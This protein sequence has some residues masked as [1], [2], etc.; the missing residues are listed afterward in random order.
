MPLGTYNLVQHFN[1]ALQIQPQLLIFLSLVTWAQCQY[2]GAKWNC[3]RV[4]GAFGLA[5]ILIG[6]VEAALYFALTV[7]H[8]KRLEWPLMLMAILAAI[9]LALGVLRYYWDIYKF[10][11]TQAISF[12][13]V[14]I[15]AAGD[16]TSLLALV[17][18]PRVNILGMVIYSTELCLWIGIGILGIYFGLWKW[19]SEKR[20]GRKDEP[21]AL[22]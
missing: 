21:E 18:E 4:F 12:L 10:K 3:K 14:G 15:D 16:L 22:P 13:F 2:Y 8:R 9:L 5:A 20:R 1:L 19:I 17:F 11:S 7:A 6:G